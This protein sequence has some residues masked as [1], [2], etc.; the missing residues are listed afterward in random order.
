MKKQLTQTVPAFSAA[1]TRWAR[2]R[3]SVKTM[4]LSPYGVEFAAA[5]ASVSSSNGWTTTT[6][7][8]ISSRH[9]RASSGAS[10]TTVGLTNQPSPRPPVTMRPPSSSTPST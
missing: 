7:P 2:L 6:G 3:F 10:T 1:E 5:T 4:A 8:K 9:T